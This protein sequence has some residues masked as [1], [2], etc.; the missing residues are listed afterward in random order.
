MKVIDQGRNMMMNIVFGEAQPSRSVLRK[1][2]LEEAK[3]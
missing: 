3:E 2:T 1:P